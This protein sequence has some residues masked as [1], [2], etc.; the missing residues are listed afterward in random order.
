LGPEEVRTGA[1]KI[2]S[3]PTAAKE[4]TA[5]QPVFTDVENGADF[6][7]HF[8]L[9]TAGMFGDVMAKDT[10]R[11]RRREDPAVAYP[12]IITGGKF[13]FAGELYQ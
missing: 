13:S 1:E 3:D 11:A 12:V 10:V 8:Y 7:L 6:R 5:Q 4:L 2:S 9:V